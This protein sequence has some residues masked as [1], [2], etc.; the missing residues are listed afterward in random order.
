MEP[1]L[2]SSKLAA[3]QPSYW[4]TARDPITPAGRPCSRIC[5]NILPSTVSTAAEYTI[6]REYE[7]IAAVAAAVEGP[8]DILGHSYGAACVLGAAP[9]IQKLRRLVLYE[10][11][12][13]RDQY[14][15]Q[16]AELL[17]RMDE[18]LADGNREA[19]VLILMNEMLRIPLA[20]ID[21][22]RATPA[23]ASQLAGAHT[24]AGALYGRGGRYR[25]RAGGAPGAVRRRLRPL[26]GQADPG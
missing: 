4:F 3:A 18:S 25:N 14:T 5:R 19:V 22:V 12:M 10:P 11:P 9:L 20:A 17:R 15:P 13:L 6:Q 16:R 2:P 26:P 1:R 21:K 7:D 23:W 8:I 24:I